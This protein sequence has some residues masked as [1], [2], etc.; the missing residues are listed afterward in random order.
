MGKNIGSIF[1][2]PFSVLAPGILNT[3][4]RESIKKTSLRSEWIKMEIGYHQSVNPSRQFSKHTCGW[5][6]QV[7]L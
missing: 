6:V 2:Y 7:R 5:L 3:Y 4:I 1:P